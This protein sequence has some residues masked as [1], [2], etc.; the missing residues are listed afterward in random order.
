MELKL[1]ATL[2]EWFSRNLVTYVTAPT[3]A[4]SLKKIENLFIG[5]D[6][7]VLNKSTMV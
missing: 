7:V 4:L 5:K 3:V 1:L 2:G 6:S